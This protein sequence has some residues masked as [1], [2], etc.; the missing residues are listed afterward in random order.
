MVYR[1]LSCEPRAF[2][3]TLPHV[4]RHIV[5]NLGAADWEGSTSMLIYL[6]D[7]YAVMRR[8]RNNMEI[9]MSPV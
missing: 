3:S 8:E 7:E 9:I 2:H 4:R 6:A 5:N 1:F